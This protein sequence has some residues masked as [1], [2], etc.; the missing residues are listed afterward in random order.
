V[1]VLALV[2]VTGPATLSWSGER[3]TVVGDGDRARGGAAGEV[4][5]S[6]VEG[7]QVER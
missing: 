7:T 5:E 4:T 1:V 6:A 2:A 3:V